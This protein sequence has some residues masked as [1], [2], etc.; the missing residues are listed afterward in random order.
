MHTRTAELK[1]FTFIANSVGCTYIAL[2][3]RV[4][5]MFVIVF[6]RNHFTRKKNIYYPLSVRNLT[7]IK[8]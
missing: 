6:I 1:E 8:I 2:N 4:M 5:A 7:R 3:L